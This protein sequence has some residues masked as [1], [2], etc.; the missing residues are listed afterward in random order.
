MLTRIRKCIEG[1]SSDIRKGRHLEAYAIFGIGV[2]LA[3]LGLLDVASTRII[4]TGIL[5]GVT[6]LTF[7]STS[8]GKKDRAIESVLLGR[9]SFG[10]FAD[11]LKDA[12]ELWVYGP[13]AINVLANAADIR[14]HVLERGGSV[15][16]IVQDPAA[17]LVELTAMQ[18][19]DNIDF[20][21]ALAGSI[22]TLTRLAR[23]AAGNFEYRL[24]S[25]NPGFSL[26]IVN[27][28]S[29]NGYL[30][31]ETHGFQDENIADRMHMVIRGSESTR[32]FSYW[33]DRFEAMWRVAR[34]A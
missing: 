7:H 8:V 20:P 9:E 24:L 21:Q 6:F 22:T 32:W 25:V 11:L 15:R 28:N 2:A 19:D 12:K 17:D 27:P 5:L 29:H 14:R 34:V 4:L 18:L 23:T 1:I 31:V 3:V 16:F 26:V 13:T 30:V 33:S 10:S